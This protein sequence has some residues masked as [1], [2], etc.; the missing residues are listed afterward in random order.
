[1]T[2]KG[3]VTIPVDIRKALGLNA[4]QRAVFTQ[5]HDGTNVMRAKTRSTLELKGMLKTAN[6]GKRKVRLSQ[7]VPGTS[8][9]GKS[10][11]MASFQQR[12]RMLL[13]W[14]SSQRLAE[15]IVL[16]GARSIRPT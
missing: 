2:S 1:M 8:T 16:F 5:L 15:Y 6:G 14:I 3:P 10:T 13:Q 4:G 11:A 7:F 9:N 12:T